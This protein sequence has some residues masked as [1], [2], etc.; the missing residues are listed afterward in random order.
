MIPFL[1]QF[2]NDQEIVVHETVVLAI[3]LLK[4][5]GAKNLSDSTDLSKSIYSSIDPAPPSSSASIPDLKAVLN[6][7]K[8]KLFERYRAMFAL[9]NIGT[10]ESVLALASGFTDSSPLFRHEIAYIFGQMQHPASVSSLINV[11]KNED[12]EGMVR[13]EAAEALGS[14]ATDECFKVLDVYRQD[15]NKV[16][17]ESCEVGMDMLVFENS[18]DFQYAQEI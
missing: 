8:L 6:D 16:V 4:F 3:D 9:R 15:E 5:T 1:E 12:E 2:I 13:H 14:I 17:R 18:G 10:T 11:L 7:S